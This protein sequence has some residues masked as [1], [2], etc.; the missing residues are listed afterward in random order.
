MKIQIASDLH[1]Q[2][3]DNWDWVEKHPLEI[4]G[5][6]LVLAGD[7][8]NL[9]FPEEYEDFYNFVEH[10]FE[11]VISINGN[12]EYYRGEITKKSK[13]IYEML[14]GNHIKLNNQVFNYGDVRFLATTLWSYV[15]R[16]FEEKTEKLFNDYH[17]IKYRGRNLK[18]RDTNRLNKFSVNFLQEALDE[19]F[20]GKTVIVTHHLPSLDLVEQ[21]DEF[22]FGQANNLEDIFAE[23]PEIDLWICGH[24]HKQID[25]VINKTRIV[26]NSLGYVPEVLPAK[27]KFDR[28]FVVEV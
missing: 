25:T 13:R 7:I 18:A 9:K 23:H 12:H 28:G 8:G 6:V 20:E 2:N 24:S 27:M 21:K 22:L 26:Q 19:K 3:S 1:L 10:N 17:R 5:E 15:P 4:K 11:Q 16:E 14:A